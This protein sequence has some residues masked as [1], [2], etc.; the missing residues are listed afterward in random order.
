MTENKKVSDVYITENN[1]ETNLIDKRVG[2]RIRLRRRLLGYSQ[3]KLALALG[4][5]FQQVQKYEKGTNRVGASRLFDIAQI[6][7]VPINFFFDELLNPIYIEEKLLDES[8]TSAVAQDVQETLEDI[9]LSE[10]VS[11]SEDENNTMFELVNSKEALH[12]LKAYYAISDLQV[13]HKL[14]HL[15]RVMG[16]SGK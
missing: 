6:L 9:S 2:A 10:L 13:R 7:Q 8:L 4:L 1:I 12:L 15:I 3:E 5:S 16:D 11:S 14:L